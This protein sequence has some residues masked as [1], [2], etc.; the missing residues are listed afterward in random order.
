VFRQFAQSYYGKLK[1]DVPISGE[2]R[3]WGHRLLK[4]LAW[5]MTSGEEKTELQV[6]I[7]R[8]K[9][10]AVLTECLRGK[11]PHPEDCGLCC[12][13]D[14]LKHHLIQLGAGD[15][16]EFRHQLIQEYYTAESLL[17][18]LP[19]LSDDT[20]KREYLNYLKWTEP[21]ALM[22]ELVDEEAQAVRVVRLALSVDLRL[23]ARLAG[24]VKP[25]FQAQTVSLVGRQDIPHPLKLYLFGITRSDSTISGLLEA[26]EDENIVVRR[27]AAYALDKIGN[28]AAIPGLLKALGDENIVV[29]RIAAYALGQIGSEAAISGLLKAL[30]DESYDVCWRAAQTL[31]KI[32]SEAAVSGLLRALEHE[33]INVRWKAADTLGEIGSEAAISGLLKALEDESYDVRWRTAYALGQIGSEAAISG[34]LKALED[35]DSNVRWRAAEALGQIGSEV[36]IPGLLKALE[37]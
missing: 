10:E 20:L 5:V 13:E 3:R 28:E 22:L 37:D 25:E 31:C 34:L 19:S 18:Q 27:I 32:G 26:L 6:A 30:E 14:L 29:R 24:A 4:H 35:E 8:Q 15:Q 11:V 1:Q 2:S 7:S 21:L 23:G 33:K 16:I 9:A 36:A 12:L 17:K